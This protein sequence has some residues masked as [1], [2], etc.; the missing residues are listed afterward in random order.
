V[1]YASA[2]YALRLPRNAGIRGE[3]GLNL[4]A[5][6]TLFPGIIFCYSVKTFCLACF[7]TIS[8]GGNTRDTRYT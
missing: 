1:R 8:P 3:P 6:L 7:S 2:R 5:T 4:A